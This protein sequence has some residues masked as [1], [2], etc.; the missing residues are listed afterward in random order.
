MTCSINEF[1]YENKLES[2]GFWNQFRWFGRLLL[3]RRADSRDD[4]VVARNSIG[5]WL[6][7]GLTRKHVAVSPNARPLPPL[8]RRRTGAGDAV[9]PCLL[10]TSPSP[11]D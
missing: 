10:Y 4:Y 7:V 2:F 6:G 5:D 3:P 1:V 8:G 11:R 9:S